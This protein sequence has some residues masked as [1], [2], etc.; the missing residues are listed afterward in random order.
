MKATRPPLQP[1]SVRLSR[2]LSAPLIC[3]LLLLG[4][5]LAPSAE[6]GFIGYYDVQKFTVFNE[7]AD[8][9]AVTPDGGLSMVLTGGNN[10]SGLPGATNFYITAFEPGFVQ[11]RYLYSSL[12][13]PAWDWASYFIGDSYLPMADT[14]GQS[15]TVSFAIAGGQSFGWRIETEDN[16]GEPAIL[17]ILDFTAPSGPATPE[18]GTLILAAL[19]AALLCGRRSKARMQEGRK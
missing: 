9:F 10:G 17:T 18:P 8:G 12:D 4:F 2:W 14:D 6:A 5:G 16:S 7:N 15:G 1:A 11:F 3:C 13:L 19:G